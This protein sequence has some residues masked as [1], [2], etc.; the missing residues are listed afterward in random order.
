MQRTS[1]SFSLQQC[2]KSAILKLDFFDPNGQKVKWIS[3]HFVNDRVTIIS[4]LGLLP[5]FQAQCV[6]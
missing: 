4:P 3:L 2:R 1:R 5:L 6:R